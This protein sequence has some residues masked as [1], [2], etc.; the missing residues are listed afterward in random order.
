MKKTTKESP[1][2]PGLSFHSEF[3]KLIFIP[4]FMLAAFLIPVIG[5]GML[6]PDSYGSLREVWSAKKTLVMTGAG[7]FLFLCLFIFT[8]SLLNRLIKAAGKKVLIVLSLLAVALQLFLVLAYP[9]QI[10]WDNTSVLSSAIS[11]VTGN[12]SYFDVDYF[13]QLGHQNCFLF[14]TVVLY[15]AALIFRIPKAYI[16]LYFSIIDLICIDLAALFTCLTVKKVKGDQ[17]AIKT[18]I[19]IILCPGMY[20]WAGYYYT[21]NMSIFFLALYIYLVCMAWDKKRSIAFYFMT[22]VL[23]GFGCSFRATML[24][25]VIATI[26]YACFKLPASP[27]RALIPAA[28][29][30]LI[31]VAFLNVSYGKMIP[32]YDKEARFPVTHWLMMAAQGNGEYN[33]ADLAFT[34]S[35]PTRAEKEEATKAEYIRRLKE[36]GPAGC[37]KLAAKKTVHNYSYGNHSYYPLFHRYDRLSDI[38]WT[39][40]NGVMFYIEQIFHL[41]ML[42]MC[43]VS[44]I[45]A[46]AKRV[47]A[48]RGKATDT[49]AK[50]N[51]SADTDKNIQAEIAKGTDSDKKITVT[52]SEVGFDGLVQILMVGGFLFYILWETYPYYSVGF[53]MVFVFLAAD[54]L[55]YISKLPEKIND[56]AMHK[57][58]MNIEGGTSDTAG[59]SAK[60]NPDRTKSSEQLQN[61]DKTEDSNTYSEKK[62]D[63]SI[64]RKSYL[65][66]LLP[67]VSV[68]CLVLV[69]TVLV[70]TP[71][72]ENVKPVVTQKKYNKMLF[73]G[74]EG[75][76]EQTF[77]ADRDFDTITFW[78]TK[79]DLADPAGGEYDI[80]INGSR[81]GEVF[82]EHY[83]TKDMGRIDEFTRTFTP[84]RI[85]SPEV[86]TLTI[87]STEKSS[88]PLGV[89]AFGMPVEAYMY[90]ELKKDSEPVEEEMFF[91]VTN[92]GPDGV[93]RL[94][95]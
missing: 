54:G 48:H 70:T 4:Y 61:S 3:Q 43:L 35:F 44:V 17:A 29:G 14:L 10:W 90:G 83:S 84:V 53:L 11:I 28:M 50:T 16:T 9:I 82:R 26:V 74:K 64:H 55:C 42:I 92:G 58:D 23:A 73:M 57:R 76:I 27:I 37:I 31:C 18:L 22:G 93:I 5:F 62:A 89:G 68:L 51:I 7:V 78:I 59:E 24:I 41:S 52:G 46:W 72:H 13:N 39:P 45:L 36:L 38:L 66:Y 30:G 8:A 77:R 33:D 32:D 21:T 20:L 69:S 71:W 2:K 40:D 49:N 75:K 15:K 12:K 95:D 65:K 88:N 47:T 79:K 34:D 25:A 56:P 60:E 6:H 87:E 19:F 85:S 91:T 1:G 81:S 86:F 63:I 94:Y 67:A 80:I